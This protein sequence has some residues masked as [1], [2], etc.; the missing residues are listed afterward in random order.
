MKNAPNVR[1]Y[2]AK[3]IQLHVVSLFF[4]SL[5]VAGS[6]LFF[7]TRSYVMEDL[8]PEIEKKSMVMSQKLISPLQKALNLGIDLHH[9]RGVEDHFESAAKNNSAIKFIHLCDDNQKILYRYTTQEDSIS[10]PL[11]NI[12][13]G[14]TLLQM[15]KKTIGSLHLG[16]DLSSHET[17]F[18]SWKIMILFIIILIVNI[19]IFTF[20][21]RSHIHAPMDAL[22]QVLKQCRKGDFSSEIMY[23]V[24]DEI[25]VF[26][27][28][29]G[30]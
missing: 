19:E 9:M 8:V 5:I 21:F 17:I 20:V 14:K 15:N 7:I 1:P 28:S 24:R 11:K 22:Q 29:L 23:P 4:L 2:I 3:N 26:N 30:Q 10:A 16:I 18:F 27:H 25:G 12:F 13:V 6:I